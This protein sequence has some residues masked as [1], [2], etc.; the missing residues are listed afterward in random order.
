[1]E[2]LLKDM[3]REQEE[4][5]SRIANAMMEHNMTREEL[6]QI[7]PHF[8]QLKDS[9][10]NFTIVSREL[11]LHKNEYGWLESAAR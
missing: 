1:M 10:A 4:L 2:V 9:L 3:Q 5:E 6:D 11:E 8:D 7:G